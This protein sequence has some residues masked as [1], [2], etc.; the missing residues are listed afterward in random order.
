MNGADVE[1]NLDD[2]VKVNDASVVIADVQACNG[3]IHVI[4]SVILPPTDTAETDEEMM[5]DEDDHEDHDGHDHGEDDHS[6]DKDEGMMKDDVATEESDTMSSGAIKSLAAA[7][8]IVTA[9]IL[10]F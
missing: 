9:G 7:F 4:D 3:V 1:I 5:K 6:E 2:G 10:S 8:A